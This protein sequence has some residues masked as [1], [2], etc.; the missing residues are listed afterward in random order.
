MKKFEGYNTIQTGCILKFFAPTSNFSLLSQKDLYSSLMLKKYVF[1]IGFILLIIFFIQYSWPRVNKNKEYESKSKNTPNLIITNEDQ[2]PIGFGIPIQKNILAAP[3]HLF[4]T[5][6]NLF[7]KNTPLQIKLRDFEHDLIFLETPWPLPL[8]KWSSEI[9]LLGETLFW[10]Y[11]S[12]TKNARVEALNT[13]FYTDQTLGSKKNLL[14]LGGIILP[15]ESGTALQK[16]SGDIV[17]MMIGAD[18]LK[19]QSYA[20]RGDIIWKVAQENDLLTE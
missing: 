9:P 15:G 12:E 16:D 1:S 8:Q 11:Q 14:L 5:H 18:S 19:H 3:D 7:Y 20:L 10:T 13:E 2:V 17:G 6:K 4:T